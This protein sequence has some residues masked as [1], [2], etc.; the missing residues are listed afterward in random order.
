VV[1]ESAGVDLPERFLGGVVCEVLE[2][3]ADLLL[4]VGALAKRDFPAGSFIKIFQIKAA[5][6][7]GLVRKD[8]T[9]FHVRD[10]SR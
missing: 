7:G 4:H 9:V 3:L 10:S 1:Q 8:L 5:S 2:L 6:G